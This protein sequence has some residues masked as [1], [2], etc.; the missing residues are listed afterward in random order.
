MSGSTVP[1]G[2]PPTRQ[3]EFED[4]V[5]ARSGALCAA[6][7]LLTGDRGLA[8]DLVQD[9]LAR[10]WRSW[11][12]LH[13]TAN[14][15]AYTRRTMYHLH[16]SRWRRRKVAEIATDAVPEPDGVDG[17]ADT[18]LRLAVHAALLSL[19]A[20]QRAA[21]VVRYFEDQTEASAAAILD[22]PVTALRSRVQRGLRRLRTSFPEL[23]VLGDSGQ[24]V[25]R[26]E[27]E[28]VTMRGEAN[29]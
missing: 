14:A 22:C 24:R 2:A 12:R 21:I 7:F 28:F 29:A 5:R 25:D 11:K 10:T 15:E 18:A 1:S 20:K 27:A 17:E 23:V 13:R 9:A 6:A 26:W 8:E 19:P 16:V 3:G 4:F